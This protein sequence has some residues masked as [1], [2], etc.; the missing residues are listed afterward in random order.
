MQARRRPFPCPV[1]ELVQHRMGWEISYY[2]AHGHVKHLA[3]AKSEPGALRVARQVAEL[4]GY[5]GE[6]IIRSATGTYK[7]R[8]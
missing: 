7:I 4:Y 1:I 3:S 8:I 2:D 5:Q 6:V